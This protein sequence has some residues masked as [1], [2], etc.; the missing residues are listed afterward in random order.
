MKKALLLLIAA[1]FAVQNL[2][3]PDFRVRGQIKGWKEAPKSFERFDPKSLYDL[4]DGGAPDY[5]KR[6]L[7]EGIRQRMN[8][9]GRQEAEIFAEDFGFPDS[10]RSMLAAMK[11]ALDARVVVPGFDTALAFAYPVVEGLSVY[12]ALDKYYFEV[13]LSRVPDQAAGLREAARFLEYYRQ[14]ISRT[15]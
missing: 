2:S 7:R 10:A 9:P 13:A 5:N 8:G 3:T 11:A 14:K 15:R 4:I 1:L 12:A 6:G